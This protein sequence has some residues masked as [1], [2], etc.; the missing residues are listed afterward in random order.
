[1]LASELEEIRSLW[2]RF[3]GKIQIRVS[4]F[5]TGF[6]G[7]FWANPK[8]D[9]EPIK[10]TLWVDSS[11]QIQIRIFEIHNLSIFF[12]KEFEKSI[13]DKRFSHKHGT[14]QM[15]YMYDIL[16]V[17]RLNCTYVGGALV[18]YYSMFV[19]YLHS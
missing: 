8:T 3:F 5:K 13:F 9:H 4:E 11:N 1:M 14:S 18:T 15:P 7:F 19:I 12:G 2:E 10:F 17:P 16:T 6:C